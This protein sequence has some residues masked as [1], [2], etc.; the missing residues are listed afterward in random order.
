MES[1]VEYCKDYIIDSLPDFEDEE[2]Y[3]CDLCSKLTESDN[4]N[5]SMTYSTYK[6][7]QYIKEWWDDCAEFYEFADMEFG[8]DY[9]SKSLN[10]F[11]NPEAFMLV[12][13]MEGIGYLLS[14]VS[15][16]DENWNDEFILDKEAIDTI[17]DEVSEMTEIEW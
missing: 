15:I 9:V 16:V 3:G 12:M 1:F 4:V 2:V 7:Q 14:R 17:I 10:V 5:G 11:A 13:V 6:A 8:S